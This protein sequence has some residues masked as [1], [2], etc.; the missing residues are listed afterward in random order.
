M[1]EAFRADGQ[2]EVV[3]VKLSYLTNMRNKVN[4]PGTSQKSYWKIIN[5]VTNIYRP[6]STTSLL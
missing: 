3:A 6:L 1:L 5:R 4:N 2:K